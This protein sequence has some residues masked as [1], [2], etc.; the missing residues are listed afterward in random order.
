MKFDGSFGLTEKS[1]VKKADR[2][3]DDGRIQADELIFEPELFLSNSLALEA[4]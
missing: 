1:P 4:S 3:I 2:Q